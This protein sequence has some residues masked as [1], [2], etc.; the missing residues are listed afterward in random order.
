GEE[1][2]SWNGGTSAKNK[3]IDLYSNHYFYASI[4]SNI[5]L[6]FSNIEKCELL[7]I[8]IATYCVSRIIYVCNDN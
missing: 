1:R 3:K 8:L 5:I 6:G 2:G 4:L 7:N